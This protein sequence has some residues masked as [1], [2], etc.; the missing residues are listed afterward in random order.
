MQTYLNYSLFPTQNQHFVLHVLNLRDGKIFGYTS[1]DMVKSALVLHPGDLYDA[2][3]GTTGCHPT[4]MPKIS[5]T[6]APSSLFTQ[7]NEQLKSYNPWPHSAS[8]PQSINLPPHPLFFDLK[9]HIRWRCAEPVSVGVQHS[10]SQCLFVC[11]VSDE[12]STMNMCYFSKKK[13]GTAKRFFF[14]LIKGNIF[15][16]CRCYPL[17]SC[18]E[19]GRE[20][21]SLMNPTFPVS[22]ASH[23]PQL[24][25]KYRS[26]ES[27]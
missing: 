27:P 19:G 14:F 9:D 7:H 22:C 1:N 13:K 24:F 17:A 26:L 6:S 15:L 11:F 21:R 12:I 2:R 18:A 3:S 25:H 16:L 10:L 5:F 8:R 4:P 20:A 23:F